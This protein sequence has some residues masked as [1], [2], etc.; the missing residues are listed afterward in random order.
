MIRVTGNDFLKHLFCHADRRFVSWHHARSS[1]PPGEGITI[2][3][4][5]SLFGVCSQLRSVLV[6]AL[7]GGVVEALDVTME[8]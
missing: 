6:N 4:F 5:K 3:G 7:G 1:P 8:C 2:M